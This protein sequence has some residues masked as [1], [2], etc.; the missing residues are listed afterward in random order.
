MRREKRTARVVAYIHPSKAERLQEFAYENNVTS[1][2]DYLFG[3]I[4]EH[5]EKQEYIRVSKQKIGARG[6]RN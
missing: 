1:V 5:I 4:E 6:G 2:S 3:L